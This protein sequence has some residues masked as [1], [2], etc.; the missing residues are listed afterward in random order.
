MFAR[1]GN[2]TVKIKDC[3]GLASL[4]G[5]AF[6]DMRGHDGALIYSNSLWMPF[7]KKNLDLLF[8]DSD[9]RV[10]DIQRA[11][12]IT[13]NPKTWK[14]YK[15]KKARYCL[16]LKTGLVHTRNGSKVFLE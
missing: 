5:L 8:L 10:I 12:P 15:N 6:D 9:F 3:K 16:E 2:K 14:D 13:L 7:V 4:F 11:V 1:I